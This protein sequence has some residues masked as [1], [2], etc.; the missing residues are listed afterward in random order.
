MLCNFGLSI[1]GTT[2]FLKDNILDTFI[3]NISNVITKNVKSNLNSEY[4][5]FYLSIII[6]IASNSNGIKYLIEN[7]EFIKDM[8]SLIQKGSF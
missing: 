5:N 3:M 8:L 1:E 7:V 4:Y 2:Y 6:S